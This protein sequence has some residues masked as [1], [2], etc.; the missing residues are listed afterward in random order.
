MC[1]FVFTEKF[2]PHVKTNKKWEEVLSKPGNRILK[3]ESCQVIWH[4]QKMSPW[5]SFRLLSFSIYGCTT[6]HLIHS[7]PRESLISN[8]LFSLNKVKADKTWVFLECLFNDA[9]RKNCV[10]LTSVQEFIEIEAWLLLTF[11]ICL[12]YQ[13]ISIHSIVTSTDVWKT[14]FIK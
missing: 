13:L 9:P 6:L 2:S 11:F 5:S 1:S 8:E 4:Q 12:H 14:W 10:L 7:T 3:F